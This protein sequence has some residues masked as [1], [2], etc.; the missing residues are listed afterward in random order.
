MSH[1]PCDV[2]LVSRLPPGQKFPPTVLQC[3]GT[4][5]SAQKRHH[6]SIPGAEHLSGAMCLRAGATPIPTGVNT[7]SVDATFNATETHCL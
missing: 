2:P 4:S 1:G 3:L 5:S 7:T 6:P